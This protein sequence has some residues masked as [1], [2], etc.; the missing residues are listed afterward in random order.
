MPAAFILKQPNANTKENNTAMLT[1]R[2]IPIVAAALSTVACSQRTTDGGNTIVKAETIL[3]GSSH[4]RPSAI[5]YRTSRDYSRNVAVTLD[6]TRTRIASYP[7]PADV[8]NG[9]ATPLNLGNG[10]WLDRRGIGPSTAFLDITYDEYAALTKAPSPDSLISHVIDSAPFTDMY[11]LP[12]TA[13]K[14]AADTSLCRRYIANGFAG[15]TPVATTPK[16]ATPP[17]SVTWNQDEK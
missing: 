5:V 17:H 16:K 10:Y 14:A 8:R 15:C 12:I 11:I 3:T 6:A 7:D 13:A 9:S 2:L 1:L 4:A